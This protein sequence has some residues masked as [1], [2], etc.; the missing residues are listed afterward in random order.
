MLPQRRTRCKRAVEMRQGLQVLCSLGLVIFFW[1]SRGQVA[2]KTLPPGAPLSQLP[3]GW[4]RSDLS[5]TQKVAGQLPAPPL[6][7]SDGD[8]DANKTETRIDP[9][10]KEEFEAALAIFAQPIAPIALQKALVH[11]RAAQRLGHPEAEGLY[12]EA[13]AKFE[14]LVAEQNR[15]IDPDLQRERMRRYRE[16]ENSQ[17]GAIEMRY[18]DWRNGQGRGL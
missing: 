3:V 5:W 9:L 2:A 11:L 15:R 13:K 8:R 12:R 10:A 18:N 6:P 4:I 17:N 14:E 1:W 16:L 7:E